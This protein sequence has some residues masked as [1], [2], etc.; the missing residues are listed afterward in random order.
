MTSPSPS[1]NG[2]STRV[3]SATEAGLFNGA[4]R[5]RRVPTRSERN[6]SSVG[7][8]TAAAEAGGFGTETATVHVERP[9]TCGFSQAMSETRSSSVSASAT[10]L[11][12]ASKACA[13]LRTW[14]GPVRSDSVPGA[15]SYSA[16]NPCAS[17]PL[18]SYFAVPRT[19]AKSSFQ[20]FSPRRAP[21]TSTVPAIL[22]T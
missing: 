5:A 8:E 12:S 20:R 2:V 14:P 7:G 1:G 4:G 9:S 3:G 6:C 16:R 10:V 13:S 11:S 18:S 22:G 15:P 17:K 19:S 21:F